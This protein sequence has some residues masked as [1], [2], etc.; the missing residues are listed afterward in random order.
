MK[1]DVKKNKTL[2][3]SNVLS[4]EVEL[5][6]ENLINNISLVVNRMINYI[7]SHGTLNVGPVIQHNIYSKDQNSKSNVRIILMIQCKDYIAN[8]EPPYKIHSKMKIKDCY[9]CH[10]RGND[11]QLQYA[12][13]K[14]Q[15][16]AFEDD[17]KLESCNYTIFLNNNKEDDT[18]YADVFIPVEK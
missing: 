13:M 7:K 2:S 3:L 1:I 9:M 12:Y 15:V 5:G 17:I 11:N 4:Y 14:I 16:E 6:T 10:Y 8:V 18:I